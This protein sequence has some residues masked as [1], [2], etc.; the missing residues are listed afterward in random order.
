[1][2]ALALMVLV[3]ALI[4][5]EFFTVGNGLLVLQQICVNLCLSIG[6]TIVILSGGIDL[7]VGSM[8]AFSG[9]V[10][11]GLLKNGFGIPGTDVFVVVHTSGRDPHRH[12]RSACALGWCNGI[13]IT[14]FKLP[15]FVATLG[16]LSIARGFTNLW[17]GGFP[18]TQLGD[19][20]SFI[21]SGIVLGVPMPVW[22]TAVLVAIFMVV[23]KRTRFGRHVY[24][25][26]GNE[27]AARLSGLNV[28]RIKLLVYTLGGALAGVAGLVNTARVNSA[29]PNAGTQL[30]TRFHRRRRDRR[31]LAQRRSRHA[32]RHGA[33]LP[34]HRRAQQRPRLARG[35]AILARCDQGR[36]DPRR[37]RDRQDEYA[38]PRF[39]T[40]LVPPALISHQRRVRRGETSSS[41][42]FTS[43]HQPLFCQP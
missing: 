31:H 6:M 11:A 27:R 8:L 39:L 26:G 22:I 43:R 17:T 41:I 4:T 12:R 40:M 13:A 33:R 42:R 14:R 18:I 21:G 1:M 20:F 15:P 29:T 24:A 37:R 5:D 16:M 36:G 10:A 2:L 23:M 34:D 32:A 25:V 38:R 7:S 3:L 28:N 35:L 9:A 19:S 30:R